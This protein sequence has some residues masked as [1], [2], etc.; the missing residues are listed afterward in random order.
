MHALLRFSEIADLRAIQEI[1]DEM[2]A[3]RLMRAPT[4]AAMIQKGRAKA[5]KDA[6]KRRGPTPGG[7]GTLFRKFEAPSGLQI[8]IGRNN[9]QNDELSTRVANRTPPSHTL[10]PLT[11]RV[12]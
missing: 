2:V 4:D 6:K 10:A 8:L 5:Q 1:Q 12:C 3:A 7:E 11:R 9:T